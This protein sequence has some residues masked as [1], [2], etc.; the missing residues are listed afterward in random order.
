MQTRDSLGVY[1]ICHTHHVFTAVTEP[2]GPEYYWSNEFVVQTRTLVGAST[3]ERLGIYELPDSFLLTVIVP[4]FN[5]CGTVGGVIASLRGL[6]LPLEIV[7]VDDGSQDGSSPILDTFGQDDDVKLIRHVK[8]LGKGAAIRTALGEATGDVVVIQDAD[9]EYNPE[10]FR[11]LLQPILANQ[12]DI[13]Y[14]TRYG[15]CDRQVSPWWHQATNGF[16][17]W[18]ASVATGPRLTDVE[19]CY[20]MARREHFEAIRDRLK[21]SRFGIEIE[22]TARWARLGLRFAE[23]PIR[24]Q[25]RWYAEGKK[26]GWKDGVRALY[27][28]AKYGLLRL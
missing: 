6:G 24:Y 16:I 10:D 11:L 21:E 5:E 13:V 3:C 28:I 19:T 25:H 22:V 26:I 14:G 23:R 15:H 2:P 7:I 4:V 18:L 1:R 9:Q 17:S 12:T 8:N 20:K 27:C